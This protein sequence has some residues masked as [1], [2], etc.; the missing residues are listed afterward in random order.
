MRAGSESLRS[1]D[2]KTL[3]E[4]PHAKS[5]VMVQAAARGVTSKDMRQKL[6][7]DLF[8]VLLVRSRR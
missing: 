7:P 3:A 5:A 8:H 1:V 2:R 4:T 6:P